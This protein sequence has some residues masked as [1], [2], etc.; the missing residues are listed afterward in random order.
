M[1]ANTIAGAVREGIATGQYRHGT[2]L[3]PVRRLAE[4]YGVSQQTAAAAY[5]LLAAL[6]MVRIEQGNGTIVTAGQSADA[7][8]GTFTPP[9][10]AA[11]PAAWKPTTSGQASE[12]TTLVRL[13]AAPD[14]MAAW[15]I[16]GTDV[17]ER[18]RIRSVDGIPVQHK[19]T[20]VPHHLA[21]ASPAGHTGIPPLLAP[22]G[23]ER[24]TPPHGTRFADWLGWS[25]E[26]TE[27]VITVEA[28]DAAASAALGM[29][30]GT[31]GFRVVAV[32]RDPQGGPVFVTINTTPLHH[33]LTLDIVG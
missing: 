27:T 7:H 10:M 22:V 19:L 20:I 21:S 2:K 32:A 14:H 11:V 23:A 26:R 25:V 13:L 3:P 24:M 31:P 12:E 29:T 5:G 9:D 30:E 18:T 15:G 4:E 6:G 33:R 8:L 16:A 1:N 17:V 28:M